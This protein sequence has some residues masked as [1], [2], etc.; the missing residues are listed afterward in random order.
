[1]NYTWLQ[2]A[3]KFAYEVEIQQYCLPSNFLTGRCA[4]VKTITPENINV[5]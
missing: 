4:S 5:S 1:M 2:S 3:D